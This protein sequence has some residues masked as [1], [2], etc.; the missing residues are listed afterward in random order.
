VFGVFRPKP[1][2]RRQG[3]SGIL[4][5]VSVQACIVSFTDHEGIRHS[6]T[7]HAQ[8]LDEAVALAVRAFREHDC[9]PGPASTIEVRPGVRA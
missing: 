1:P 5:L 3:E 9:V 2:W 6:V 7:V 8:T 4:S